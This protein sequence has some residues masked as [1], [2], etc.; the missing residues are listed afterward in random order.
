MG[1]RARL[2]HDRSNRPHRR[3]GRV[4]TTHSANRATARAL[5]GRG[6]G[7]AAGLESEED[8]GESALVELLAQFDVT[9]LGLMQILPGH[10]WGLDEGSTGSASPGPAPSTPSPDA[11]VS[12]TVNP[13]TETVRPEADIAADHGRP[14]VSGWTTPAYAIAVPVASPTRARIDVT[15]DFEI[16]LAEEFTGTRLEIL[17]DHEQGHVTIGTEAARA[18]LV[19]GLEASLEQLPAFSP[20]AIQSRLGAAAA[21]F[22]TNEGAASAAYDA[23]D[24]PRMLE[25]YLGA[26]TPLADLASVSEPIMTLAEVMHD[27]AHGDPAGSG[28][29]EWRRIGAALERA[30]DSL[31]EVDAARVQYNPGFRQLVEECQRQ[32]DGLVAGLETDDLTGTATTEPVAARRAL[33]DIQAVL[34]RFD[35]RP[36]L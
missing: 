12:L 30:W 25:A 8:R 22:V 18:D 10:G 15:L 17:R 23:A 2:R 14:G 5:S 1:A 31:S 3:D 6:R 19:D 26:R 21:G 11:V 34:S 13:P 4:S 24:Y 28:P 7:G 9:N 16:E 27:F 20:Q 29:R 35:W 36:S 33:E 32:V